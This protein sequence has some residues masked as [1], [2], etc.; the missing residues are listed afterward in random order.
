METRRQSSQG[1][2]DGLV[3]V[4]AATLQDA[5]RR[6]RKDFGADAVI[7]GS[8]TV[9]RR[10]AR[11][12]GRERFVEVMVQSDA[13]A[14]AGTRLPRATT[15]DGDLAGEVARIE[16]MVA[17]IEEQH[18]RLVQGAPEVSANPLARVLAAA[19]ATDDTVAHLLARF[20]GETGR[21]EHDRPG[22]MSWLAENLPASNSDW[23]GFYGCHAFLGRADTGRSELVLGVAA[24]LTAR[25]RRTLMLS[26]MPAHRGEVRRLQAAAALGRFDA[27]V[28]QKTE[29][30]ATVTEHLNDYDAVLLDLP[31]LDSPAMS[32]GG[33]LHRWL[34]ANEDFHR[35]L[36]LPLDGDV[37]DQ[38][39]L[40]PLARDWSC[41][42]LALTHTHRSRYW[43]KVLDLQLAF[44]LAL[45]LLAP[46][47]NETVPVIATAGGLLDRMLG[48]EE[49]AE[50]GNLN[51]FVAAAPV[52]AAG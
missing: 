3:A 12:L 30:I 51:E 15:I 17:A 11:G 21:P 18:A 26:I 8:R 39:D 28:I 31:E 48:A 9:D 46:S 13:G 27:A 6:V 50:Q 29:L 32:A 43:A 36:V 25:G 22:F 37:R 45:S 1:A 10:Q 14:G 16:D 40:A 24:E 19:G 35:H 34:A 44:G 42:W 38:A 41:D 7:V 2:D 20:T 47:R 23:N 49:S 5:F 4:A 33:A 52:T